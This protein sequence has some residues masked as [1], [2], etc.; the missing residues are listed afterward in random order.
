LDVY[1]ELFVAPDA[2][3]SLPT[4]IT[5]V[6]GFVMFEL[7][8][9]ALAATGHRMPALVLAVIALL[10]AGLAVVWRQQQ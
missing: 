8:A 4:T 6:L 7:A 3:V 1:D 10:N 2:A 9:I 5:L